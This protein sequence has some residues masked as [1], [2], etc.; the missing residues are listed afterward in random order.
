[1]KNA[2]KMYIVAVLGAFCCSVALADKMPDVVGPK[3]WSV[4]C[5]SC[6]L[7]FPP[8]LLVASDWETL[9][10]GLPKHFG[11]DASMT[12]VEMTETLRFLVD[13]AS[14]R[15]SQHQSSVNPPRI[16]RTVW[17]EREHRKVPAGVW[18][19][20][21]VKSAAQCAACHTQA[22]K[23]SFRGREIEVPGYPGKHW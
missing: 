20:A 14:R 8:S 10:A 13:N 4:D 21:R 12:P 1:V 2:F 11:S 5:A 18:A 3:S 19:D 17:F 22:E 7:A 15:G 16:T 23:N 9:V 6:H